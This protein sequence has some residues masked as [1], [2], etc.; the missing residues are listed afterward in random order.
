MREIEELKRQLAEIQTKIEELE[1]ETQFKRVEKGKEYF[2]VCCKS[3][4]TTTVRWTDTDDEIDVDY[5]NSNNY[6]R[7]RERAE[8]VAKSIRVLLR[9]WRLHDT[10][11]EDYVPNWDEEEEMKWIVFYSHAARTWCKECWLTN[12]FLLPCFPT[13]E[14]VQKACDILNE[15]GFKP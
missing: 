1:K 3:R 13:K 14:L 11:C 6:F 8:E 5:Y 7:T 15:E 9:L 4:G 12:D 10:L 2:T